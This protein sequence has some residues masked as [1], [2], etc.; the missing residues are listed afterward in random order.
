MVKFA[1]SWLLPTSLPKQKRFCKV[2]NSNTDIKCGLYVYCNILV[3]CVKAWNISSHYFSKL[4]H[5]KLLIFSELLQHTYNVAKNNVI[6]RA[7][8][9]RKTSVRKQ[10]LAHV[11]VNCKLTFIMY[12][13]FTYFAI[14]IPRD[15]CMGSCSQV[16]HKQATCPTKVCSSTNLFRPK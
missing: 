13:S 16:V 7:M 6:Y 4:I 1:S 2:A 12:L 15:I 14:L 5:V 8:I 11:T 3:N 10:L 9:H